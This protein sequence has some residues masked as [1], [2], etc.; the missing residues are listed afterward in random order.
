MQ[1]SIREVARLLKVSENTVF[2]WVHD[3][4]LPA[5][6]VDSQYFFN[7]SELLEWAALKKIDV[8]AE[9]FAPG[10]GGNGATPM[11]SA[12]LAAGGIHYGLAGTDR[13]SVLRSVVERLR[14]PPDFDRDMLLA[15]LLA[16]EQHGSTAIGDGIAIP[17]PRTPIVAD[18]DAPSVALCYL[19]QPVPYGASDGKPVQVVFTI[20]AGNVRM[21]FQLIARLAC[22]LRDEN[23]RR[24]V[25]SQARPEVILAA[26]AEI[27][28]AEAA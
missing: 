28:T 14:L 19:N 7:K 2:R 17:H 9:I 3:Q 21:H 6:Q 25:L 16:R 22:T 13:D 11:L 26:A 27:D 1:L 24:V 23:F 20:L 18:I 8:A 5:Q 12:A 4:A 10:P 15:L